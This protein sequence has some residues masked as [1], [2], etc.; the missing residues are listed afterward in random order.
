MFSPFV[1]LCS[2]IPQLYFPILLLEMIS[3]YSSIIVSSFAS[4]IKFLKF[5]VTFN[6]VMLY[7]T[8][9]I[10][11]FPLNSHIYVLFQS[12]SCEGPSSNIW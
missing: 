9:C 4:K 6:Y 5:L 3:D 11:F 1:L 7:L 2:T 12:L 10:V 8:L